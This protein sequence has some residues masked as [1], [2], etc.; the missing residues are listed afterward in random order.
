MYCLD[1]SSVYS[2]QQENCF[3]VPAQ[4]RFAARLDDYLAKVNTDLNKLTRRVWWTG[5]KGHILKNQPMGR[6][7]VGKV[8]H[9]VA[10]CLNLAKP[11]DY[12]FH[13]YRIPSASSA[14]K[15]G[16]TNEQIQGFYGWKHA[17]PYARST[18][19]PLRN[20]PKLGRKIVRPLHFLFG[21]F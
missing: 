2:D 14:A 15:G 17:Y 19:P 6:N 11:N 7:M 9:D 20:R 21:P 18:S 12:T 10:T 5:T 1:A 13:S 8:P 4:G 3:L 16:M